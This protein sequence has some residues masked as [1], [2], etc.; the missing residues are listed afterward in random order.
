MVLQII[1]DE[2]EFVGNYRGDDSLE[3]NR[4]F[5]SKVQKEVN[6]RLQKN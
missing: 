5:R 3:F 2:F 4:A 6:D 1:P